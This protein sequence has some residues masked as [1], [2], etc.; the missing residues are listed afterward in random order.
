MS[1]WVPNIGGN[2]RTA[3]L[4]RA[5]L[6][7]ALGMGVTAF[8]YLLLVIAGAPT[9]PAVIGLESI[10][11][12]VTAGV[13]LRRQSTP[14]DPGPPLPTFPLTWILAIAALVMIALFISAFLTSSELNP[15]GGWD[16]FAI[17][18]L[19][20]H[21]LLHTETWRFAVTSQSTGSHMEYPLLLSSLVA[22]GWLYAGATTASAPISIALIVA[23]ALAARLR[24]SLSILRSPAVGLLAVLILLVNPSFWSAAPEQYADLPLALFGLA[25]ATLLVLDPDPQGSPRYLT[26][27]GLFASFAA[28]T[29]NEGTLLLAAL[30]AA[31]LVTTWRGA[32]HALRR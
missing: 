28:G 30:A 10:A 26:L 3:P 20:A 24:S 25:S 32:G 7:A 15:Q 31:L 2:G 27:A 5:S 19:R 11:L 13:S 16:A 23:L 1:L 8:L 4:L 29:K 9:R 17:W 12:I 6:G 21:Y 22:R 14:A 18:N